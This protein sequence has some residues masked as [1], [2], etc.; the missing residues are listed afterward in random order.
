MVPT[1]TEQTVLAPF[2]VS[3]AR[4]QPTF[5]THLGQKKSGRKA[6]PAVPTL[7]ALPAVPALPTVPALPFSLPASSRLVPEEPEA[8]L[9]L[10]LSFEK[11]PKDSFSYKTSDVLSVFKV[12]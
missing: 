2:G 8:S 1:C 6:M 12:F 4:Q 10:T 9:L 3:L 7:P 5:W 11:A